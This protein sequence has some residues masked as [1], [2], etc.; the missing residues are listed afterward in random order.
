[1]S[2]ELNKE[3]V[4]IKN[5]QINQCERCGKEIKKRLLVFNSKKECFICGKNICSDCISKEERIENLSTRKGYC[6]LDCYP[7]TKASHSSS[8]IPGVAD[9]NGA[10]DSIESRIPEQLE[11]ISFKIEK[12]DH[13]TESLNKIMI[14]IENV[15]E[16][17]NNII[18]TINRQVSEV[19]DFSQDFTHRN[20]KSIQKDIYVILAFSGIGIIILTFILT[21]MIMYLIKYI[22][23]LL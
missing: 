9:I 12:V 16:A 6:C 10:V 4:P 20:W 19:K 1:M 14:G 23:P 11:I 21:L 18:E 8:L 2:E 15:N 13:V 7:K 3:L 17:I 22:Y 5:Y